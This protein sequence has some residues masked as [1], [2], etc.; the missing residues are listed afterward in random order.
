MI[1]RWLVLRLEAPLMAFGDIAV[2]HVA[3]VNDFPAT[4]MLAGLIGNALGWHWSDASAHQAVQE[5]LIHAARRE[6]E[7]TLLADI[8]NAQLSK[9]DK[10]WTTS[11]MPEGRA[12]ASY[13]APHRRRRD[14]HADLSV[15][16]VLRL[17]SAT[18][19]PTLESVAEAFERPARPLYLGRKPCLPSLPLLSDQTIR[20]VDGAN[21]YEALRAVPGS[22][23]PRRASWP[24]GQGPSTGGGVDCV[25]DRADL[26]NWDSG[27][28]G[29]SRRVVE[30]WVTP[31]FDG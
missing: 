5:R 18:E 11:G 1:H 10:G 31:E 19:S 30:G 22:Q 26:R 9:N 23:E 15:R 6:R 29:G 8:Q 20:W 13:A 24:F 7:G 3:P 16:V 28:H 4:S 17:E 14:F 27:L 21:A 2:D 12:G 25:A